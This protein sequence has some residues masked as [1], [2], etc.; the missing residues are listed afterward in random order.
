MNKK[1][2]LLLI[3]IF[4]IFITF[5]ITFFIIWFWPVRNDNYKEVAYQELPSDVR[6][7]FK[8]VYDYKE[9]PKISS[10]GDTVWYSPPFVECYNI[11]DE[12]CLCEIESKGG[13]VRDPFFVLISCDNTKKMSWAILQRV[14]IIKNDSIYYPW[15][16]SA[17][18]RSGE[19]RSFHVKIDTLKF[20]IEKM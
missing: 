12:N 2:L 7:K 13:I 10:K 6:K 18:T 4:S 5:F 1:T 20:R 14:F 3:V 8:E 9:P 17:G 15:A 11:I 19:S 16:N